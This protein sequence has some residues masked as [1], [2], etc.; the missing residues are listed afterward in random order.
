MLKL[1]KDHREVL[2]IETNSYGKQC[3]SFSQLLLLSSSWFFTLNTDIF[4]YG[5]LLVHIT[6]TIALTLCHTIVPSLHITS[7][8]LIQYMAYL[9]TR[10]Y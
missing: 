8:I 1:F 10:T 7:F 5:F 4:L 3:Q 2:K 6:T 9:H